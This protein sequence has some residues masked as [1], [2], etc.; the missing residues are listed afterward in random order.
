MRRHHV[1]RPRRLRRRGG[2]AILEFAVSLPLLA[3]V[4]VCTFF[5]GW[6]VMNQQHVWIADRYACW[7][8]VR[9]GSTATAQELNQ[10][11]FGGRAT[12]ISTARDSGSSKTEQDFVSAVAAD[13]RPAGDLA[14][15][16]VMNR[17]P[18]GLHVSIQA[19]FPTSVKY[20]QR[21]TGAIQSS[22]ER[23]GVE[24]RWRQ[25]FCASV[26]ADQLLQPLD[27]ML[28]VWP[29]PATNVGR[30]FRTLYRED[31]SYHDW[32]YGTD[33]NLN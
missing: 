19:E 17:F 9:N 16:L 11:F 32:P 13:N 3:L 31:W 21:F 30:F 15:E 5:F 1:H 33:G 23:E 29:A 27:N 24:W 10:N 14:Q 6:A 28:S 7:R 4:L 18:K 22:H 8:Q 12:N 2:T 26:V 20:W 25:A